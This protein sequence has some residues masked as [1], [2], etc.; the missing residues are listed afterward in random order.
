VTDTEERRPTGWLALLACFFASGFAAL[1]YQTAWTREFGAVFGTSELAVA[2]VLAAYMGGLAAGAALAGRFAPRVRR[3]VLA[4]GLLELGIA[5]AALAV[6]LAIRAA[7]ALQVALL[8]GRELP[9]DAGGFASALFY[10]ACAFAILLVPTTFMGATL[11]LLARHAVRTDREVGPRIGTLYAVN[12]AG[13]IGGTLVCGF[14]LLPALGLR[15]TVWAGV[16]LN[17]LVFALAAWVARAQ[18]REAAPAGAAA[19]AE[20]AVAASGSLLPR[21]A[22]ILPLA[23]LSGAVSFAYEVLW[24]RLLGHVLGGSI[25]AFATMLASVLVGIALG[26]ALGAR[27]ATTPRA[28]ARGF[29]FAQVATAVLATLAFRALDAVPAFATR[30]GAGSSAGLA[31]NAAL[32]MAILVPPALAIGTTFPFAVRVLARGPHEASRASARVYAWNTAGAITGSI[33]AGFFVLPALGY[34]GT[35]VAAVA[36]NLLLALAAAALAPG[37]APLAA[38]AIAA[39]LL[40]AARPA[41]PWRLL[42]TSPLSGQT[43]AGEVSFFRVGRAATVLMLRR[44]GRQD[45]RTNGLPESSIAPRGAR[46]GAELVA[47]WL[48]VLPAAARPELSRMLIVGLGGGLAV[49]SVPANVAAIDVVELEPEVV[50]ANRWLARW[51]RR[52]PFADPRVQVRTNDARSALLLSDARYDAIVSQPSHPWGAGA[53]HL[54]TREFF[55]LARSRLAPGGVFVQWIGLSFVD[56]DLLRS[57]LAT[58]VEVFP[59]VRVYRPNPAGV[60][61]LSSDAPLDVEGAAERAIARAAADFAHSGIAVREDLAAALALDESGARALAQGAAIS[62]D[63][64]NRLA[65][66]SP[67]VLSAPIGG[68]GASELFAEHDPL[69]PPPAGLDAGYLARRVAAIGLVERAQRIADSLATPAARSAAGAQVA[70]ARGRSGEALRLAGEALALEPANARAAEAA[71]AAGS[72]AARDAALAGSLGAG[73]QAYA[74][75][76][77]RSRVGDWGAVEARDAALA[78]IDPRSP[79]AVEATRIRVGWRLERGD[80]ASA[81]EA[82]ALLDPQLTRF[83]NRSDLRLRAKLAANAGEIAGALA[84]WLELAAGGPP[85]ERRAARE[86]ALALARSPR[87]AALGAEERAAW[88]RD[89][90]APAARTANR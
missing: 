52:D 77:E 4:Y 2:T 84:T 23:L 20:R 78:A 45:L 48:S 49:E 37:A 66:R 57:L 41:E 60:L 13:A 68:A 70:L 59:N 40:A 62:S 85:A 46:P 7:T 65:T 67:K 79:L 50:R 3:P 56:E 43:A 87:A 29:A 69:V 72:P 12:T 47:A 21:A 19:E 64:R 9:A 26:G 6:P 74:I 58:L 36:T 86:S 39:A 83:S 44:D 89:L 80:A 42:R 61:F 22:A 54:Y 18:P 5:G 11:P 30:L 1:L 25:Y 32:A 38:A 71:L 35:L 14:L 81:R 17:A 28:A 16:A 53:S 51:R 55:A 88:L 27:F 34:A 33:A 90:E 76:D 63:D 15:G 31:A 73:A 75:A 24:T 82:L 10:L 8:G